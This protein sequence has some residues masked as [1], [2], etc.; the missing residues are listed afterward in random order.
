MTDK[1]SKHFEW[2]LDKSDRILLVGVLFSIALGIISYYLLGKDEI[3]IL[4]GICHSLLLIII[5]LN[6]KYIYLFNKQKLDLLSKVSGLESSIKNLISIQPFDLVN[7][8]KEID[9]VKIT[10]SN[11]SLMRLVGQLYM[12][13][14]HQGKQNSKFVDVIRNLT[15]SDKVKKLTKELSGGYTIFQG[16]NSIDATKSLYELGVKE[17]NAISYPSIDFWNGDY[18]KAFL[19]RN[20]K[21]VS[22]GIKINRYFL[23]NDTGSDD[24]LDKLIETLKIHLDFKK[25][26]TMVDYNINLVR[27]FKPQEIDLILKSKPEWMHFEEK[28]DSSI[29]G[30]P[31]A[32]LIGSDI[33]SIWSFGE[34]KSDLEDVQLIFK[35]NLVLEMIDLFD[36]FKKREYEVTELPTKDFLK[37]FYSKPWEI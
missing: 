27:K 29:D 11:E 28:N 17:I 31:D 37:D 19:Y 36:F 4:L 21:S 35:R 20:K 33:V 25:E 12:V 3:A 24:Q 6:L 23:V 7:R 26:K 34:V 1:N 15:L 9:T 5:S 8:I 32:S 13:L 18:G 30:I 2:P 16:P 22:D 14:E 10:S